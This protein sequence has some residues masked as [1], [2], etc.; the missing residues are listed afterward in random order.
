MMMDPKGKREGTE[1]GR[2][3]LGI[4]DHDQTEGHSIGF[5]TSLLASRENEVAI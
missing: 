2:I 3:D 5:G 4:Q 1:R